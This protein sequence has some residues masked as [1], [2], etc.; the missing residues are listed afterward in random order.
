MENIS[1]FLEAWECHDIRRAK[2]LLGGLDL[3]SLTEKNL[4]EEPAA[5]LRDS[6]SINKIKKRDGKGDTALHLAVREDH[7][8]MMKCLVELDASLCNCRNKVGENPLKLAVSLGFEEA[9]EFLITHSS[10]ALHYIVELNQVKLLQYLI[11]KEVKLSKLINQP[12]QPATNPP[13]NEEE[14]CPTD[15]SSDGGDEPSESADENKNK[16]EEKNTRNSIADEAI[17]VIG[18]TPL[19]I[20]ARNKYGQMVNLLLKVPGVDK[21][22]LN[23]EDKTPF[24]IARNVT[25]YHESFRTIRRLRGSRPGPRRFMYCAPEVSHIKYNN[26]MSTLNKAYEA[27][28][29]AEL[30]V[31][32]LLA[33]MTCAAL[34]TVPGGF[35]SESPSDVQHDQGSPLLVSLVS[36]KLFIIF[37]CIA[38]FL[39]LFVCTMWE[40]SADLNTKNKRLFM[41]VNAMVVCLS[42]GFSASGFMCA[43][44]AMLARKARF[45]RLVGV[46]WFFDDIVE[47]VWFAAER[48]RL[49]NLC[50]SGED[51]SE[52][53]MTGHWKF[54]SHKGDDRSNNSHLS[55]SCC[56]NH[57]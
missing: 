8:N 23:N 24:E 30:V 22:A 42:F 15:A 41:N 38:F 48:C 50:V 36:F 45:D 29:D 49:L 7:L 12:Y 37:D 2:D 33:T 5:R 26:A 44:Y 19:H 47:K 11:Q 25:E 43:V 6:G 57:V 51:V 9:V 56:F 1:A 53:L 21:L 4:L 18:D 31:A 55:F 46:S 39:S 34:F 20:A 3:S 10:N 16:A 27:R 13:D 32:A 52:D 17:V 40:L 28:R 14:K 35:N 54:K